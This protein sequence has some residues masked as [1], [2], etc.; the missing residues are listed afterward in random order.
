MTPAERAQ[1]VADRLPPLTEAQRS[2][3]AALLAGAVASRETVAVTK[4]T[5]ALEGGGR[6]ASAA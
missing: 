5:S 1:A 3:L 4:P 6:D 2:T